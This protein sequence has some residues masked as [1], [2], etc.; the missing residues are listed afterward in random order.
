[1]LEAFQPDLEGSEFAARAAVLASVSLAGAL[2]RTPPT[3]RTT[4]RR[5]RFIIGGAIR[6]GLV[7]TTPSLTDLEDDDL[8]THI[9]FRRDHAA[10]R[11]I[12]SGC[13]CERRRAE[14]SSRCCSSRG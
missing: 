11:M 5:R 2:P 14:P 7:G 1:M 12:G 13:L 8:N 6:H 9:D 3:G 4:V 10:A